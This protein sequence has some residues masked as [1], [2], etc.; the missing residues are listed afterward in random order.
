MNWLSYIYPQELERFSSTYNHDIRVQIENGESK[1]LVNGSRQSGKYIHDLWQFAIQKLFPHTPLPITRI[2]VLGV[3]GGT[4]IHILHNMYP[5]AEITG[6]DIDPEM[7]RIGKTYFGLDKIEKLKVIESDAQKF[8]TKK[9]FDLIVVDLFSG[10]II[11]DFVLSEKFHKHIQTMLI[12]N[13]SVF[14]NYLREK[15]YGEKADTLEK[16]LVELYAK[17]LHIDRYNNRFFLAH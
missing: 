3:A 15:E 10:R 17:V 8:T 5:E 2:L 1:L 11:P 14:I 6:V 4:V 7:I 12:K 13:G 9:K 16:I